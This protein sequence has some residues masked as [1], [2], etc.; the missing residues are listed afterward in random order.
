M[1]KTWETLWK[2]GSRFLKHNPKMIVSRRRVV[3][4]QHENHPGVQSWSELSSLFCA[5]ANEEVVGN[6]LE[7][8]TWSA[9]SSGPLD[10][11]PGSV[12]R[13]PLCDLQ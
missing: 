13:E 9:L 6:R 7:A 10:V 3:F 12:E 1:P 2:L 11:H 5:K 4:S 8:R